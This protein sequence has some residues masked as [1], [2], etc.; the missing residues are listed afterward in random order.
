MLINDY[1]FLG[2]EYYNSRQV[3]ILKKL[4]EVCQDE[5]EFVWSAQQ[6]ITELAFELGF[7]ARSKRIFIVMDDEINDWFCYLVERD[8]HGLKG[9]VL[10]YVTDT[11]KGL[12]SESYLVG[13]M[14][15]F[16][17]RH[18]DEF[19]KRFEQQQPELAEILRELDWPAERDKFFSNDPE[20]KKV[21]LE[22][23]NAKGKGHLLEYILGEDLAL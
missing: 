10:K 1:V 13:V 20:F 12:L 7:E 4:A 18:R 14:K 16:V 11:Y 8:I 23:L 19:I 21:L 9:I 22:R 15:S 5:T 3:F 2:E 17:E 6:K